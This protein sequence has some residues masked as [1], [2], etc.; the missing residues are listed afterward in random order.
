M[1][2]TCLV[3]ILKSDVL[4]EDFTNIEE[5]IDG[6]AS[7]RQQLLDMRNCWE[8]FFLD[9]FS[10]LL[11][12]YQFFFL[13]VPYF[14]TILL[15]YITKYEKINT[16]AKILYISKSLF[17]FPLSCFP[18]NSH[19]IIYTQIQ[20]QFFFRKQC[21]QVY[22]SSTFGEIFLHSNICSCESKCHTVLCQLTAY[23]DSFYAVRQVCCF[24][25]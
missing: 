23:K 9:Y 19:S 15:Y 6:V 2:D 21:R 18:F 3:P 5:L 7:D 12:N 14:F 4:M 1:A 24:C 22:L 17:L 25:V 10:I 11:S 13:R 20:V 16:F 8:V